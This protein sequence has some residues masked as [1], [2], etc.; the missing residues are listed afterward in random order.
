MSAPESVMLPGAEAWELWRFPQKSEP[1]CE[2]SPTEKSISSAPGLLFALPTRSVMAM[3]LWVAGEGDPR[4]LAELELS[5]RH[6]VRRDAAVRAI[7]VESSGGRSL[8][9]ALA[10]SNDSPGA[11]WFSKAMCFDVPAR[12][13]DP[14]GADVA[15]WKESGTLCFGFYRGGKCVAF[16]ASGESAPGPAFCGMLTRLALRLRAEDVIVGLPASIRLIGGFSEE[17]RT[18][19]AGTLRAEVELVSP[20]PPPR[21]PETTVDIPPPAAQQARERRAIFQRAAFFGVIAA[22]VYGFVLLLLAGEMALKTIQLRKLK[23][24]AEAAA[25]AAAEAKK[26][27]S[28]WKEFQGAVNPEHFALDQLAAV[29]SELPGDQVR[30]TQFVLENGRLILSGEA[31]DISQAYQ[32]LERV[33]KS[34][35]LQDYDWTARQPQLAGKNKVQFEMEG[36][37]PDA[38]TRDE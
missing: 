21:I 35:V 38:K 24:E 5:G 3:P 19:L 23:A 1:R 26:L 16:S 20:A 28:E 2:M 18:S 10:V 34:P 36:A 14:A 13:V 25:P 29:A 37:R 30:L 27:V 15:V 8:I 4:E 22:A 11:A 12:L 31:A 33:K 6:L 7:P 9:L 32:F 17:D